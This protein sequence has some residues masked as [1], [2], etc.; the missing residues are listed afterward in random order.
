MEF[1]D[2]ESFGVNNLMRYKAT[3]SKNNPISPIVVYL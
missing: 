2:L 3:V 1:A